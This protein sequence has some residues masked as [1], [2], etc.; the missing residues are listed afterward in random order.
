[1]LT[2][3]RLKELFYYDS[4]R[5]FKFTKNGNFRKSTQVGSIN[6]AGYRMINIERKSYMEHRLIWLYHYG[7]WP[8]YEIDHLNR[9]RS[10]N[11]IENLRD[12]TRK[13][14]IQN[15]SRKIKAKK[16]HS[17]VYAVKTN[18]GVRFDAIITVN[19]TTI[20]LGR[21]ISSSTAENAYR[22]AKNFYEK[23]LT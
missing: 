17:G 12:V 9:N 4:G 5:L 15:T 22:Y 13:I 14:N 16:S 20:C 21:F 2:Q 18:D 1:M 3:A 11:R 23:S 19:K 6:S 10:D 7:E 8:K